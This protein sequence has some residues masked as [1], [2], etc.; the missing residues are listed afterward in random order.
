MHQQLVASEFK[1]EEINLEANDRFPNNSLPALIYRKAL[2]L[3]ENNQNEEACKELLLRNNWGNN[4][5]DSIF[6]FHHFHSNTHE[7]LA[8]TAGNA[9][10]VLGGPGHDAIFLHRGDVLIIPAGV[11]HKKKNSSSDFKCVGGYA[12]GRD[13]D[14]NTGNDQELEKVIKEMRVVPLPETDPVTGK[15]DTILSYWK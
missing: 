12:G 9:E 14:M 5:T 2:N 8:I 6:D 10:V 13:Y 11:A 4:W 1:V 7:V 3:D 15:K